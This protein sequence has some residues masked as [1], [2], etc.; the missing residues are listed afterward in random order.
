MTD[1]WDPL[2]PTPEEVH[3]IL[4]DTQVIYPAPLDEVPWYPKPR[5]VRALMTS[6]PW[7]LWVMNPRLDWIVPHPDVNLRHHTNMVLTPLHGPCLSP[8]RRLGHAFLQ[9]VRHGEVVQSHRARYISN[10]G[11][12]GP[13]F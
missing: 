5:H 9:R 8:I 10:Q 11:T 2:W 4:Q 6:D 13:D 3:R 7:L 12:F 1:E